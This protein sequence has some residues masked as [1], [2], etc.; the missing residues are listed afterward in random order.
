MVAIPQESNGIKKFLLAC[1]GY[2]FFSAAGAAGGL[3][4]A[5]KEPINPKL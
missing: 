2:H 4:T 1:S 5:T 3:A